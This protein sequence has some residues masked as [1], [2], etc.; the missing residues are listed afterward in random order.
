MTVSVSCRLR[1]FR[2]KSS[3]KRPHSFRRRLPASILQSYIR[4]RG[5]AQGRVPESNDI[6]GQA[7][8]RRA[9]GNCI[10]HYHEE[11]NHQGLARQRDGGR[12]PLTAYEQEADLGGARRRSRPGRDGD[13]G[14]GRRLQRSG[15]RRADRRR[16]PRRLHRAG[17]AGHRR[18]ATVRPSCSARWASLSRRTSTQ[19]PAGGTP[20]PSRRHRLHGRGDFTSST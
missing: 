8:S 12:R 13:V 4:H 3:R 19:P 17:Q 9:V 14:G 2:R 20:S 5:W 10:E 6:I 16:A 15:V 18:P 11:R 1:I 7:S